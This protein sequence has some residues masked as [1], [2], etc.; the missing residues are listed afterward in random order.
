M[1]TTNFRAQLAQPS[2]RP[3]LVSRRTNIDHMTPMPQPRLVRLQ[4]LLLLLALELVSDLVL[5]DPE[6]PI[7]SQVGALGQNS[8]LYERTTDQGPMTSEA[9][10]TDRFDSDRACGATGAAGAGVGQAPGGASGGYAG[11]DQQDTTQRARR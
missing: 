1:L 3:V 10:G 5:S 8:Y 6:L 9:A 2:E 11:Y 4:M 7:N